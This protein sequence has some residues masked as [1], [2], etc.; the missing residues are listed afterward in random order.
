MAFKVS[1]IA[2]ISLLVICSVMAFVSYTQQRSQLYEELYHLESMFHSPL[3]TELERIEQ[4]KAELKRNPEAY[5][6]VPE[7]IRLQEEMDRN[8]A[9]DYVENAY[10]FYPE[11][12]TKNGSKA[13]LN[14]LSNAELYESEKPAATYVPQPD[15]LRALEE[16]ERNGY[17]ITEAYSDAFGT[18]ISVVSALRDKEGA[19]VA[20]VGMDFDYNFLMDRLHQKLISSILIGL[21]A[22]VLGIV[23]MLLVVRL[24]LRPIHPLIASAQA[25]AQGDLSGRLNTARKDEI[26]LL[27]SHFNAML[28]SIRP[29]ISHIGQASQQVSAASGDLLSRAKHNE[30]AIRHMTAA[31]GEISGRASQQLHSTRESSRAMEE[32]AGGI[33]RVAESAGAA[34]EASEQASGSSAEGNERMKRNLEQIGEVRTSVERSAAAMKRLQE[35]SGQIGEMTVLISHVS[36]QTNMLALNASI[37]AVRAGEHGRGFAVVSEE[38]RKL[39]DQSKVSTERI[40]E[41]IE[42]IQLETASVAEAMGHGAQEFESMQE[43]VI[44][45]AESFKSLQQIIREVAA[46]MAEVSAVSE[47]MSAGTEQVTASIAELADM[48]RYVAESS[49]GA[50]QA[51]VRQQAYIGEITGTANRLSVT[52]LEL[53]GAV[54]KF[55]L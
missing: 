1:G 54:D 40:K 34:A 10:L 37:E 45:T 20:F 42:Q 50:A 53:Q 32:M 55:K 9:S 4:A 35:L 30:E 15:L 6:T 12:M 48:S 7:V 46:Q 26:G 16:A 38:I 2:A 29:L 33:Q 17:G 13:L 25:V 27:T 36:Q 23:V 31:I 14:L 49:D 18:W 24:A 39:A 51:A 43:V 21:A 5:K 8:A 19:L 52:S 22:A 11:W 44:Q 47:Q 28:D 3:S 41:L